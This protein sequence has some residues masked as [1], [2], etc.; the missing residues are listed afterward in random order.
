M[1]KTRVPIKEKHV[2]QFVIARYGSNTATIDLTKKSMLGVLTELAC[3]KIGYRH[4]L[5]KVDLD[6][7]ICITLLYPD[8]MKNHFIHPGKLDLVA[9]S[10]NYLFTQAF[11]EALEVSVMLGISD[12]E[13]VNLFMERYGI[14]EDMVAADTL[15]KK[16]RDHQR[17][18][19][20]KVASMLQIA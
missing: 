2:R 10:L 9:K 17:Y 16:W 1:L 15:R 18:M 8:S 12:Y 5:P 11:L 4:V 13:A 19:N 6:E 7:S 20:K 14:T 3:E